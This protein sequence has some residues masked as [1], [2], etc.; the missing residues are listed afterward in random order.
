MAY[1]EEICDAV[2]KVKVVSWE[3]IHRERFPL[4][5]AGIYS[6]LCRNA[7]VLLK[8]QAADALR[9]SVRLAAAEAEETSQEEPEAPQPGVLR[10]VARRQRRLRIRT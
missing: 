3:A 6:E 4:T 5:P 7:Q 10:A 1:V 2:G 8:R 9:R